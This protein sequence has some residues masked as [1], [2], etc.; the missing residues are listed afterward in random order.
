MK[1]WLLAAALG[2]LFAC[3]NNP[4]GPTGGTLK[5]T[6]T[7]PNSGNDGAILLSISGPAALTSVAAGPGLTLYS[8]PPLGATPRLI[9][10]GT[11]VTGTVVTIG[12]TDVSNAAAYTATIQ[13]VAAPNYVL[14]DLTGYSLTVTH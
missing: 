12:V 9:L 1:R 10:T 3:A 4:A 13:Q 11:L 8:Q 6:L 5:V 14:R 7:T 2:V